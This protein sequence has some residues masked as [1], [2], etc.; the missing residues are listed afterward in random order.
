MEN[1][2]KNSIIIYK[3]KLIYNAFTCIR[4]V[5]GLIRLTLLNRYSSDTYFINYLHASYF[6]GIYSPRCKLFKTPLRRIEYIAYLF[7]F[8]L[9]GSYFTIIIFTS[10]ISFNFVETF[11]SMSCKTTQKQTPPTLRSAG[12]LY[13]VFSKTVTLRFLSKNRNALSEIFSLIN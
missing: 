5:S 3:E 10:L 4:F 1:I 7:T 9:G 2:I 11:S 8:C 13:P 12:G 6:T